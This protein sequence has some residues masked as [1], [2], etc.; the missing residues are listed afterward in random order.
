M[1][2]TVHKFRYFTWFS[3]LFLGISYLY[4]GGQRFREMTPW[5][6]LILRDVVWV[7]F[8][9]T[10]LVSMRTADYFQRLWKTGYGHF[11]KVCFWAGGAYVVIVLTHVLHKDITEVLQHDLRNILLYSL[12]LPIL[13]F[14]VKRKEGLSD[15]RN[16]MLYIG[17]ALSLFG[18]ASRMLMPDLLTW[19]GR[20]TAMMGDPNNFGVFIAFCSLLIVASWN[21]MGR[22][23]SILLFIVYSLALV[24]ANSATAILMLLSGLLVLLMVRGKPV[25]AGLILVA[26]IYLLTFLSLVVKVAEN[27]KVPLGDLVQTTYDV[28][29]YLVDKLENLSRGVFSNVFLLGLEFPS[30]EAVR[31]LT[32][33]LKQTPLTVMRGD[34]VD[35]L[36][37]NYG[38]KKYVLHENQYYNFI[39]NA[40]LISCFLF[41]G[42]FI[43][44]FVQAIRTYLAH[45]DHVM[46]P[47]ILA[48]AAFIAALVFVGFNSL[49]L[50]NRYPL[51]FLM[52]L[53]VGTVFLS[54]D[55][56]A[57]ENED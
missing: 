56:L 54:R 43:W 19:N 17:L 35:L 5:Y 51:N 50:L 12:I 44:V 4:G 7:F 33:R 38:T 24:L 8:L 28:D 15:L 22:R 45:R 55:L 40:G 25:R 36:F 42:L 9:L 3:F 53:L 2:S 13:P 18:I 31:S 27:P 20:I 34:A 46:A 47:F 14:I 30:P 48:I 39:A 6:V 26:V 16:L 21:E 37:G 57:R 49:A 23:K 32:H 41:L 1:F 11:I 10:L 29:R 52:Y